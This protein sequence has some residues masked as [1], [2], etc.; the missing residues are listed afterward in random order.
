MSIGAPRLQSQAEDTA[1]QFMKEIRGRTYP[2]FFIF[3]LFCFGFL[4]VFSSSESDKKTCLQ[5]C[6]NEQ[7]S[8]KE[9]TN[10]GRNQRTCINAMTDKCLLL[11]SSKQV[12]NII[13]K[14]SCIG[15]GLPT[16]ILS[17]IIFNHFILLLMHNRLCPWSRG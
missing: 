6:D 2:A 14:H 5:I 12:N 8:D 10:H 4:S 9:Y 17:R 11:T 15:L 1:S 13:W 16:H 7:K 3:F